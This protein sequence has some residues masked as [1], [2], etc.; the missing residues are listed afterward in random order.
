MRVQNIYQFN[1]GDGSVIHVVKT[2][3]FSI[4]FILFKLKKLVKIKHYTVH[5]INRNVIRII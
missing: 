5:N 1:G 4:L 3:E 2:H